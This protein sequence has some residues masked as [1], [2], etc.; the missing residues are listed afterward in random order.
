[1]SKLQNTLFEFQRQDV[2]RMLMLPKCINANVMGSGKSLEALALVERLNARHVLIT[3]KKP[4]IRGWFNFIDEWSDGDCLTPN[5]Q[6][7]RLDGLNLNGP[8]YVVV[9]HDLLASR[10]YWSK[11]QEV[12]WDIV[13]HDEAHK[14]KNHKSVRTQYA[15]LMKPARRVF[16]TGT[17]MEN[18][19][20]DLFPYF[21][22]ID[23]AKFNSIRQ[24]DN[25]FCVWNQSEVWLKGLDG[26]PHPRLIK[27]IIP[28]KTNHTEELNFL[29]HQ[30]MIR[31]E[32]SEIMPQLPP[33]LYKQVP[34]ELGPE[35]AQYIQMRDELF[36]MLDSGEQVTAP[37]VI[38]QL[39]RLRQICCEP[40]LLSSDEVKTSTPS[41]KTVALLSL[42][43]DTDEKVLV[44]SV[45]E[46]YCRILASEFEKRG[47]KYVTITGKNKET[48][49]AQNE[50]AFQHDPSIKVCLGTI[51]SMGESFTLTE[52]KIVV[53]TDLFWTP[54]QNEQCEDRTYGR[55]NRGLDQ[56]DSICV[57]DL[58]NV[59]TVEEHVHQIVR[60]KREII[61]EVVIRKNVIDMMR[62][63]I[64]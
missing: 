31:H 46:Q 16:V 32:R 61:N 13:I 2:E 57:V 35:K 55:V 21:H 9:N 6:G 30:Y 60:N 43:E 26:K 12:K 8:H 41:N 11:L 23:A 22:M 3:C 7:N 34:V 24:W 44:F 49:N 14:F 47:I 62:N 18:S 10:E 48:V 45:F 59:G 19:P 50:F 36:A 38:A 51:G 52:A 5:E 54:T 53:F 17:P 37:K 63:E 25:Y 58:F 28:G 20:H 40:N 29:L 27:S 4:F 64:A 15:Y 1:M 39:M 42:L 33:K 56:T